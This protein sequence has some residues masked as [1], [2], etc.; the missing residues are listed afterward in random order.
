[1]CKEGS[2]QKEGSEKKKTSKLFHNFFELDVK[3]SLAIFYH[4]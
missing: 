1:M 4:S 3:F 2:D